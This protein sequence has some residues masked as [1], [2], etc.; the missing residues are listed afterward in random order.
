MGASS[1]FCVSP[2]WTNAMKEPIWKA[3]KKPSDGPINND[4]CYLCTDR[5]AS[6]IV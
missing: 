1:M 5:F 2:S 4:I 6:L 3:I